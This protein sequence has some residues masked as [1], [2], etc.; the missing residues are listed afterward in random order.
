[1]GGVIDIWH[2]A[3][4]VSD[5]ARSEDFYVAKLGFALIGREDSP[6]KRQILVSVKP[7]GFTLVL[8]QQLQDSLIV[9]RHPDHL[10]FECEY[11]EEFHAKLRQAGLTYLPRVETLPSGARRFALSDPDGVQLH[12]FQGR[13]IY[14]AGLQEGEAARR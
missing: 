8:F 12:F 7:R 13:E 1:M 5:L 2:V 11:I 6:Q 3:I 10:A 14:E 9:P 4:P